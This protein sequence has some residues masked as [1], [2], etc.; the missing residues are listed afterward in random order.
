MHFSAI[1][2]MLCRDCMEIK[3]DAAGLDHLATYP[4][5]S[6][7]PQTMGWAL[8]SLST[9]LQRLRDGGA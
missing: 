5:L 7:D 1:S 2:A 6:A 8:L 3:I 4:R 9:D